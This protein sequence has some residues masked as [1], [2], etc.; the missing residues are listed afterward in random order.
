MPDLAILLLSGI[1]VF[2]GAVLQGGTGTGLALVSTPVVQLLEP[3]LMPGAMLVVA[4]GLAVLTV[5]DEAR[6]ADW[7]GLRWALGGRLVGTAGSA[8][9]AAIATVQGLSLLNGAVILLVAVVVAL[10]PSRLPRNRFT[11][12]TSGMFAGVAGTTAAIGGPLIALV[13]R[14]SSAPTMRGSLGVFTTFGSL[15][16]LSCVA[17]MGS[18]SWTQ[19]VGGLVLL[20]FVGAGFLVSAR[21]RRHLE[22]RWIQGAVLVM[23]ALAAVSLILRSLLG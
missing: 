5:A 4:F 9:A 2:I 12:V 18:L 14:G 8:W 22:Q 11:L 1:A 20:P 19:I 7:S 23:V 6:H 15:L 16:S 21:V 3:D 17:L 13:Y 10:A